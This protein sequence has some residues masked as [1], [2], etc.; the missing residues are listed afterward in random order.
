MFVMRDNRLQAVIAPITP[1]STV[2][3]DW[4]QLDDEMST[5]GQ[6][7]R[8]QPAVRF[9][10]DFLALHCARMPIKLFEVTPTQEGQADKREWLRTHDV[11]KLL[12]Q[13]SGTQGAV[14]FW[15]HV[16]QD[17][18]IYD[19]MLL[20]KIRDPET[21][22][23]HALIRVPPV[24][25]T[26]FGQDYWHP[27]VMRIIGNR[28]Q[29]DIPMDDC[30]YFHGY[31]PSDPRIGISPLETLKIMLDEEF[32]SQKWRERFWESGAQPGIIVT[33]PVDAPDWDGNDR[34][35]FIQNLRS[36]MNRGKP[37]LLEEGM[38]SNPTKAFDPGT[39]Q[40]L[41]SK[42]FTR[43][44]VIRAYGLPI[45][46]FDPKSANFSSI[47]QYRSMLYAEAVGPT[48]QR[49]VDELQVQLLP[50]WVPDPFDAGWDLEVMVDEKVRGNIIE[51]L[52]TLTQGA[53]R[54]ILTAEE[55][56]YFGGLATSG[57]KTADDL[58]LPVGVTVSGMPTTAPINPAT[59]ETG[60][61]G[62]NGKPESEP[63][64][65]LPKRTGFLDSGNLKYIRQDGPSDKPYCVY[66]ESGRNMGC[67]PTR[68]EA[69]DRL[70]QIERFASITSAEA[71]TKALSPEQAAKRQAAHQR[72]N[73]KSYQLI[74][75]FFER[76]AASV[77]SRLGAEHA[78]AFDRAR[79]DKELADIFF[80]LSIAIAEYFGKEQAEE[81]GGTY[82]L[83]RTRK[84]WLKNATM[85]AEN[86]NDSTEKRLDEGDD[87]TMVFMDLAT[88]RAKSYALTRTT[89]AM[90]WGI[91]EAVRQYG[92]E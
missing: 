65:T 43:E 58:V 6:I 47:A 25:F 80:K 7:Y 89:A 55:A 40:Y 28:S 37:L 68:G 81:M 44:E 88:T 77:K 84:F 71:A 72:W 24:W 82:N 79:W 1:Y 15:R 52:P 3:S 67:Y 90:N 30:I 12:S 32:A 54:P 48:V 2:Q 63:V 41:E 73:E 66:G 10:V 53:G 83:D 16:W 74:S 11:Q 62:D 5:Y 35:R 60:N 92:V 76:Q 85:G 42:T 49:L 78:K 51:I 36:A 17:F 61:V 23:P 69:E 8:K 31:D 21:R 13:P 9:V 91:M 86:I 27:T 56:R 19:R 14:N 29:I 39:A 64:I 26:P 87:P 59:S 70:E 50:D 33:R 57:D 38:Q 34:D 75:Q 20:V 45:G 18:F 22:K 4:I 46:L